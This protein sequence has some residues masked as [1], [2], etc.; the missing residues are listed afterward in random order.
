MY[1]LVAMRKVIW[2]FF[3]ENVIKVFRFEFFSR[4]LWP[5]SSDLYFF[6]KMWSKSSDLDTCVFGSS[7]HHGG[8]DAGSEPYSIYMNVGTIKWNKHLSQT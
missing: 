4:K 1:A 2:I 6:M 3:Y 8:I 5:K 7:D